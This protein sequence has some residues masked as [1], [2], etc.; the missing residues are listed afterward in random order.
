MALIV[1]LIAVGAAELIEARD[2]YSVR[3]AMWPRRRLSDLEGS[4]AALRA[5]PHGGKPRYERISNK[6][7]RVGT[8]RGHI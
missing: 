2:W 3:S 5:D 1:P 4:E 7:G 8:P 6:R